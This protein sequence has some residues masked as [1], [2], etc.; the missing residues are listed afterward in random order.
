[1]KKLSLKMR[2]IITFIILSITSITAL[3]INT[4]LEYSK[5][6]VHELYERELNDLKTRSLILDEGVKQYDD[7]TV[8][9]FAD[10]EIRKIL[11]L[12]EETAQEDYGKNLVFVKEKL[13]NMDFHLYSTNITSMI[14]ASPNKIY[15]SYDWGGDITT[16][17]NEFYEKLKEKNGKFVIFDTDEYS[18]VRTQNLETFAVGRLIIGDDM[19]EAGYE[20]IFISSDFFKSLIKNQ[21]VNKEVSYYIISDNENIMY[22]RTNSNLDIEDE[23]IIEKIRNNHN[24]YFTEV[25]GDKNLLVC[26]YKSNYTGWIQVSVIELKD[27][28]AVIKTTVIKSILVSA[29]LILLSILIIL[30]IIRSITKPITDIQNVMI[31]ISNGDMSLRVPAY[32]LPEISGLAEHF[33][34]MLDKI[35]LLIYENNKKQEML[36][37]VEFQMLQAQIN[38]HFVY[39]TLNSIRWLAIFNGQE[40]IKQQ[41]DYLTVLLRASISDARSEVPLEQEISVL[42]CYAEIM[43]MRYYNFQ[44]EVQVGEH[45]EKCLVPKFILQ[46]MVENAILHGLADCDEGLVSVRS[47]CEDGCLHVQIMDNGVGMTEEQMQECMQQ[48]GNKFN[49]IGIM[50]VQQRITLM[51]GEDYGIFISSK[52][53]EGTK[54]DIKLPIK[55][56]GEACD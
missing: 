8:K 29:V 45:T 53:G 37:H 20:M 48:Q 3:L 52:T 23:I 32:N 36:R 9:I 50:N 13:K 7:L 19:K 34:Q 46:P 6:M 25:I 1:M 56:E 2:L 4:Q 26:Q 47:I 38:P 44:L 18:H 42:K 22:S 31:K 10:S 55:E 21:D 11:Q 49:H 5:Q 28:I 17:E 15:A 24:K 14:L 12:D 35:N 40:Q 33:N 51:Y 39:N 27:V 16:Y 41:I 30:G 43:R 54:V